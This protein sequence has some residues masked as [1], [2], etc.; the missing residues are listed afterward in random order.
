MMG[1]PMLSKHISEVRSAASKVK[2][3]PWTRIYMI[4]AV[5]RLH[6]Q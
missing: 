2:H 3:I 6:L 1:E 5:I 4:F